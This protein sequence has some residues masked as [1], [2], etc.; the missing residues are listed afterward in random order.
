MSRVIIN[1]GDSGLTVRNALN[2]MTSELYAGIIVP[3]KYANQS[4]NFTASIPADTWVEQIFITPQSGVPD[5]KIGISIGGSEILDTSLIGNY[6]PILVQ[7]Y[8][9]S[10]TTLYFTPSGGAIN[11]R[12]DI[13]TSYK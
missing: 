10:A 11:V 1:N 7:Q 6:S 3:I 5:I 2:S 8:F 4:A 12:I 9:G 13:I